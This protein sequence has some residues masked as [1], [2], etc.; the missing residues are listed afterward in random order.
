MVSEEE[1]IQIESTLPTVDFFGD[2]NTRARTALS[3][4]RSQSSR[5]L[6]KGNC[7]DTSLTVTVGTP[8]I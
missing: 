5:G 7:L 3:Q 6:S 2:F 4:Y 1:E 8:V